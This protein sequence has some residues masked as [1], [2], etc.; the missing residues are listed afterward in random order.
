MDLTLGEMDLT[1]FVWISLFRNERNRREALRATVQRHGKV[2]SPLYG[3][4]QRLRHDGSQSKMRLLGL[5]ALEV[6]VFGIGQS[7][8][9]YT[10]TKS[11]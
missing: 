11:P 2:L 1:F 6:R 5:R 7:D 3:G 4:F 8:R 10:V 9:I